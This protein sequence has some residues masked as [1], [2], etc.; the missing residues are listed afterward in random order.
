M[1]I[2]GVVLGLLVIARR[3]IGASLLQRDSA[4]TRYVDN[5]DLPGPLR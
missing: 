3:A 4:L 1:F 5:L 2:S